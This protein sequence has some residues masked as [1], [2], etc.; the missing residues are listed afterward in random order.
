MICPP[1]LRTRA[2]ALALLLAACAAADEQ[3]PTPSRGTT[4]E[5]ARASGDEASGG[6]RESDVSFDY[7]QPVSERLRSGGQPTDADLNAAAASGYAMVISLRPDDETTGDDSEKALVERLGMRFVRIPVGG[8]EDLT[9]A[10]VHEL[11]EALSSA[12]GPVLIHCSSGNRSGALLGLRAY[13]IGGVSGDEAVS[14]AR[15]GGM[16]RLTTALTEKIRRLCAS[17]PQRCPGGQSELHS[18]D[19]NVGG[20]EEPS[21]ADDAPETAE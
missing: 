9:E 8:A 17:E 7:G 13:I 12:S 1:H 10:A 11:D 3:Q 6:R 19:V 4:P 20:V 15:G 16:T 5:V 21:L 2:V 18:D 14:I